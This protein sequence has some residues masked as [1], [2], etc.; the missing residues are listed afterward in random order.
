[1]ASLRASTEPIDMIPSPELV[2]LLSE[3]RKS[4]GSALRID[5]W[6]PGEAKALFLACSNTKSEDLN[7]STVIGCLL[8]LNDF[9]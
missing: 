5:K 1:M 9:Y 2:V 4:T 6:S 3:Q 8:S 7:Q